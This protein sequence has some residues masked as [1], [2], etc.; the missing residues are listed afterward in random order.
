MVLPVALTSI[1]FFSR[2]TRYDSE[3]DSQGELFT[4]MQET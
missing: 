4:V 3:M 1:L 2:I